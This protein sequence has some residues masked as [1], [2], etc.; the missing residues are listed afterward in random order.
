MALEK[1]TTIDKIEIIENDNILRVTRKTEIAEDSEV[2][3]VSYATERFE[4]QDPNDLP[5]ELQPYVKEI[6][7]L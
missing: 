4:K 1:T 6:W 2:A 7:K 5:T 3:S